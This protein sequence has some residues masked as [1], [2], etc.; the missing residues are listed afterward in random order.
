MTFISQ[1][2]FKPLDWLSK[3]NDKKYKLY[4]FVVS[5]LL[6]SKLL[7]LSNQKKQKCRLSNESDL[8]LKKIRK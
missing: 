4:I 5:P 3:L 6:L 2:N 8:I 1:W 7:D